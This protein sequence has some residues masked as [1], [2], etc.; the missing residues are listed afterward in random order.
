MAIGGV[1]F[2][3]YGVD[4]EPLTV[5]LIHQI[6]PYTNI[7]HQRE[8]YQTTVERGFLQA[9]DKNSY[10]LTEQGRE[11]MGRFY[12][13]AGTAV[14]ELQLL[15]EAK[16]KQLISLL[17]RIIETT[18]A[19]DIAKPFFI[20]SR[21]SDPGADAPI[22]IRI[23]QYLTDFLRY[24]DDAH[25]AAWHEHHLCGHTW[26]AFSDIWQDGAKTAVSLAE[27]HANRH[28]TAEQYTAGL[29]KL[30]ERG[31]LFK[32]E[33]EY[34]ITEKGKNLRNQA[35]EKTNQNFY[36]GWN[37]LNNKERATLVSLLQETHQNLRREAMKKVW[38][39]TDGVLGGAAPLYAD[40]T[41]AIMAEKGLDKPGH[42]FC[43]VAGINN[44][45]PSRL[46]CQ[47]AP[48]LPLHEPQSV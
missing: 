16:A 45:S 21:R 39:H 33:D 48:T 19:S 47:F 8:E 29:D 31:W 27:T 20:M 7:D 4:P 12:E 11:V 38:A 35:E 5:D 15:D 17:Q 41:R 2:L 9:V 28:I 24:R 23:D 14:A 6:N 13:T 34:H 43:H 32:K 42:V 46:A 1:P 30:V 25:L 44:G 40:E 22:P 10:Q 26:E 18:E 3:A 37:A 36:M